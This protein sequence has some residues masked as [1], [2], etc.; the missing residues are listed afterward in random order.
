M[1]ETFF[2]TRSKK[3]PGLLSRPRVGKWGFWT[4]CSSVIGWRKKYC[5]LI[6]WQNPLTQTA[7]LIWE[8]SPPYGLKSVQN[9]LSISEKSFSWTQLRYLTESETKWGPSNILVFKAR[10]A[11]PD[12]FPLLR[13]FASLDGKFDAIWPRSWICSKGISKEKLSLKYGFKVFFC[14]SGLQQ[15]I[16]IFW[17]W[18]SGSKQTR[19]YEL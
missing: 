15:L 6:G 18:P 13:I 3:N 8:F 19:K 2:L 5:L 10:R 11:G 16:F 7:K 4:V 9:S 14:F 17:F 1:T 12:A